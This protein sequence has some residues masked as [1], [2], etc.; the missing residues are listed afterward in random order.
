MPLKLST[1]V[2]NAALVTLVS[3][4][5]HAGPFAPDTGD[6]A[7]YSDTRLAITFDTAPSLGS[8]GKIKVFT[9]DGTLVDTI[10]V[11]D[12]VSKMSGETQT[13]FSARNTEIDK[14]GGNVPSLAQWR[15]VYYRPVVISGSTASIKLHDGALRPD[16]A[17]YVNIDNG[18]LN[19]KVAGASFRGVSGTSAWTFKTKATPGSPTAVTVDDDGPADFRTVQGALD[20]IMQN[21]CVTCAYAGAAKTITVKNGNYRELLFLRNVNN[22]TITG[23]SRSGVIV[24]YDNSDSFNPGTGFGTTSAGAT[25]VSAGPNVGTRRYLGGG[26]NVLLA[27]NA[28]LLKLTNFTL[29]N[30]HRKTSGWDNQAETMYFNSSTL[31]G[32]RLSALSMNFMSAQDTLLLKGWSWF[33]KS[34]VSG[35]V[36]FIWGSP[37][38]ALFEQSELHTI[39]DGTNA[40]SGGYIF[41]ARAAYGYPG[42][43][44]LNSKLTADAAIPAGSTWLARSGGLAPPTYCTTKT[45][46]GGLGSANLGCDNLAYINTRMGTHIRTAGWQATPAPTPA[47]PTATAGW[48]ERGSMDLSGNTLNVSGRNQNVSSTGIDLSG[49]DTRTE[50]FQAWNNGAGWVPATP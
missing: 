32:S 35:D 42:F 48:R 47:T 31:G 28:D 23:E 6:T 38:A 21:G 40:S 26:R 37:Y 20:W 29:W 5:A 15:Y 46:T 22:L 14:L 41:Q 17:Y 19:G 33:Y 13:L 10:D 39:V 30:A 24:F 49:L 9:T 11:S 2:V 25:L 43:V 44:V 34:Y 18:V 3:P 45:T 1:L 27:E 12:A 7:A 36:D 16:T 8:A 4:G 50:V